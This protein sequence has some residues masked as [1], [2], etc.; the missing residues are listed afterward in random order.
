MLNLF[1]DQKVEIAIQG[2]WMIPLSGDPL[3][4]NSPLFTG[5]Q[6]VS[7]WIRLET[8]SMTQIISGP[9]NPPEISRH[10]MMTYDHI[11]PIIIWR[12]Y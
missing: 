4:L 1:Y 2:L 6:Y 8:S 12:C 11:G 3:D 5:I 10:L 9:I 7:S